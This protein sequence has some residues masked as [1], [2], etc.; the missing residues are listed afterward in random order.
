[1][2]GNKL[3]EVR[4]RIKLTQEDVSKKL[5][6]PRSTYSNYELGAREPDLETIS[7]LAQLFNVSVDWLSGNNKKVDVTNEE[8]KI[9]AEILNEL[10]KISEDD[11]EYLLG[12]L[13][14]M[15]KV[16]T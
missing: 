8:D 4:K 10:K 7:A 5:G 11:K 9:N 15:R 1:M 16:K 2:L 6:I 14:R 3:S 12:L 13:K